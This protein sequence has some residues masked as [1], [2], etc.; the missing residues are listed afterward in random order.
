MCISVEVEKREEAI[1]SQTFSSGVANGKRV[2]K[3]EYTNI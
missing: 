1:N 3:D 2:M